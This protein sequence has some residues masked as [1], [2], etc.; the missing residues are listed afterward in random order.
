MSPQ[1]DVTTKI[2]TVNLRTPESLI[3][4]SFEPPFPIPLAAYVTAPQVFE[5]WWKLLGYVLVCLIR[6]RFRRCPTFSPMRSGDLS[7]G[8]CRSHPG[9]LAAVC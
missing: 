8:M 2:S 4:E 6:I 3:L 1:H 9:L 7:S 5:F